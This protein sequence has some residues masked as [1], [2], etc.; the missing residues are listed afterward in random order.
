[1]YGTQEVIRQCV[2]P[3]MLVKYQGKTWRASANTRGKLYLFNLTES[4]R[5]SDY[6]VEICLDSRGQPLIH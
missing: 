6:L 2:L 5:I 1:M 4:K 3:G